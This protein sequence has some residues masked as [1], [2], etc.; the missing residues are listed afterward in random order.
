MGL[1]GGGG[2]GAAKG[3]GGGGGTRTAFVQKIRQGG[4]GTTSRVERGLKR[5]PVNGL[6]LC[7]CFQ[8]GK[9]KESLRGNTWSASLAGGPL[10]PSINRYG[11][12]GINLAAYCLQI[13]LPG[14]LHTHQFLR[15]LAY[16]SVFWLL[17]YRAVSWLLAYRSISPAF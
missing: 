9:A 11:F 12:H 13:N 16:S 14:F 5:D 6:G 4:L 3:G 2:G 7:R 8:C 10:K 17:A 1:K 15:L